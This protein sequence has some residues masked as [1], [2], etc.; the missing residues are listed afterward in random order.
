M[1]YFKVLKECLS[2]NNIY[3][4]NFKEVDLFII[5]SISHLT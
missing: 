5:E 4:F 2:P 1:I 3:L